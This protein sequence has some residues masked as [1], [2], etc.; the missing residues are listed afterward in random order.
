MKDLKSICRV[1]VV[2]ATPVLFDKDATIDKAIKLIEEAGEQNADIIVFPESFIPAYPRGFSYGFIV[3]SRTMEGREDWKTYYDNSVIVPS[4][5]TD[6]IAEA[7]R[8]AGAYVCMGITERSEKNCTLYCTTV[9]FG[10]DGKILGKH[11]KMK[12]TGTERLIW[13]DGNEGMLTTID[14]EFGTMGG[15]ICWENYMPLMR[16]ALYEKGV[17]LYV[18]PTA[19]NREEWQCTMRHIALEGRC[20]VISCNQYV[21]KSMYPELFHYQNELEQLPEDL[22]P[23]GSC[24]VDPFGKYVIEPVWNKEEI[25]YAD[26]DMNKVPLSRMDFDPTGHYSRPDTFELV[27]H[28]EK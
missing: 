21:T 13:G 24:I 22:C 16:A 18:A 9:Y 7:A 17:A 28:N 20:Y 11:R 4:A 2:Q 6:R 8:D 23:G 26:L 14:T 5:D 19:D 1:A 12:P 10:P 27:I 3:G 15:L 25:L